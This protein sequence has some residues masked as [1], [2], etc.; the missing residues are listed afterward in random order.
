MLKHTDNFIFYNISPETEPNVSPD[1]IGM[2]D[3]LVIPGIPS[4]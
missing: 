2:P 4:I 1:I 3:M